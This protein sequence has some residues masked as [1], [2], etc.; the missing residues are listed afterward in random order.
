M[1]LY[2]RQCHA[3]LWWFSKWGNEDCLLSAGARLMQD[4]G[5]ARGPE[6]LCNRSDAKWSAVWRG[7]PRPAHLDNEL[8]CNPKLRWTAVYPPRSPSLVLSHQSPLWLHTSPLSLVPELISPPQPDLFHPVILPIFWLTTSLLCVTF[9]WC[10]LLLGIGRLMQ[11]SLSV[12]V[13][14]IIT[15]ISTNTFLSKIHHSMRKQ[16]PSPSWD[17]PAFPQLLFSHR[18]YCKL[19][20]LTFCAAADSG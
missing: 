5:E 2:E 20:G 19:G 16:G 10:F 13:S 12:R 7:H 4:R 9:F 1:F 8:R 3:L 11:T 17:I 15:T 6:L 14:H 18:Q